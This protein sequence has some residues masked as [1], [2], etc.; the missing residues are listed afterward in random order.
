[1]NISKN[2]SFFCFICIN[3]I[4]FLSTMSIVFDIWVK[5]QILL[6]DKDNYIAIMIA[7]ISNYS[8]LFFPNH[9]VLL[10]NNFTTDM[11]ISA[12]FLFIIMIIFIYLSYK[13]YYKYGFIIFFSIYILLSIISS[14][15]TFLL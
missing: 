7:N 8:Y 6:F 15:L 5:D 11:K 9:F 1:M 2:T 10:I 14:L 12:I 13:L 3:F 4:S